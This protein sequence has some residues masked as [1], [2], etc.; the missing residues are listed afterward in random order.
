MKNE[1][2][3]ILKFICFDMTWLRNYH[4]AN[5]NKFHVT[6]SGDIGNQPEGEWTTMQPKPITKGITPILKV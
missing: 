1:L 3:D 2:D 5:A 4:V 6:L